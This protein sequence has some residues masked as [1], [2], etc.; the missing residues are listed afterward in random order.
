MKQEE[1]SR[2]KVYKGDHYPD[3][4]I[5]ASFSGLQSGEAQRRLNEAIE[6][7]FQSVNLSAECIDRHCASILGNS[8]LF[9]FSDPRGENDLTTVADAIAQ[10]LL[11]NWKEEAL[12]NDDN[13]LDFIEFLDPHPV[14][15]S[16]LLACVI[17][18]GYLRLYS[19]PEDRVNQNPGD[20]ISLHSPHPD[21]IDISRNSAG[22]IQRIAYSFLDSD[23]QS[24]REVQQLTLTRKTAFWIES[25]KGEVVEGSY[26]EIDLG[27]RFTVFEIKRPSLITPSVTQNQKAINFTLTMMLRNVAYGGNRNTNITNAQRPGRWENDP[28][29]GERR[30][31]PDEAA[32]LSVSPGAVNFIQGIPVFDNEGTLT[33]YSTPTVVSS[34]PVSPDTFIKTFDLFAVA[35]YRNFRQAYVL[36]AEMNLSGRSRESLK[37]D[38]V[39]LVKRDC[40]QLSVIFRAVLQCA[41]LMAVD[42]PEYFKPLNL[43]V[44][45]KP[46][47]S[48]PTADQARE[49]RANLTEGLTS[50]ARTMTAIGIEDSDAEIILMREEKRSGVYP[51]QTIQDLSSVIKEPEALSSDGAQSVSNSEM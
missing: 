42:D 44:Q 4:W 50:L 1:L 17:G 9:Y 16:F 38:A 41:V 12:I 45:F 2:I 22:R 8:P 19:L 24:R 7:F 6:A 29:T 25:E 10:K 51:H 30:F 31:I 11:N 23:G 32:S 47:L 3:L 35:M 49:A 43:V 33:G 39:S 27:G 34:D 20:R 18:R 26:F 15:K 5:G 40:D 46:S 13:S 37:D 14:S 48:T 21:S 28:I 36:A